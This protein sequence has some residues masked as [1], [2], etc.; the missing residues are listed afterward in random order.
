[1]IIIIDYG[2]GNL[3]SIKNM[4]KK[5]GVSSEIT[6]DHSK[7]DKATKLILPG[8]GAFD[9]GMKNL[10]D[11]NLIDILNKKVLIDKI[12][13]LGICLGM[14]LM[15][16]SSEEGILNGLNWVNGS[17]IRFNDSFNGEK[18]RI[19]HMGWNILYP[20]NSN[21]ENDIF[22][23]NFEEL[24]FYFVHSY[25]AQ[26]E[27]PQEVIGLT[28]YGGRFVSAFKKDN[29]IGM[30]F[31]PEKSHKFGMSVLKNFIEKC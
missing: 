14:Q 17:V 29:I 15:L 2:L 4:L 5:L 18:L 19:P 28:E 21:L 9:D 25:F 20:Q 8:V 26:I 10:K 24:R 3:G 27:N 12:P 22:H 23:S 6:D 7:I 30:Q 31:H 13:I 16:K 1:M 11:K